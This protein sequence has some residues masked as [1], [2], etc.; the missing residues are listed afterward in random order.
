MPA[1]RLTAAKIR[2]YLPRELAIE[3]VTV[4]HELSSTNLPVLKAAERGEKEGF[5]AVA[6]RQTAG[7]G[8]RGHTFF[9]PDE[10]G[11]YFS[12][13]LRPS[14][15]FPE[16]AARITA[17]AAV[18]LA[19]AV[20]SLFGREPSVKWVNDLFLDDR[21]VAGI[22][23]RGI[24]EESGALSAVILGI[25]VNL[26]PPG[27]GFPEELLDIAGAILPHPIE[28][29]R[30]R[31][32]SAFL[33]EFLPSY[34]ENREFLEEYRRLSF[35]LGRTVSFQTPEGMKEGTALSVDE[36]CRLV[37]ALSSGETVSLSSGEVSVKMSRTQKER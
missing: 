10:T 11:L 32:L 14:Q 4:Y 7:V 13:L 17:R 30:A 27:T 33:A 3:S 21:K 1:D 12:L 23:T 22:L 6:E 18:S 34:R 26:Y 28:D 35:L 31:L 19:H 29:G 36:E 9:S 20:T 37:L 24:A 16:D 2:H 15:F 8:R 25:G 5:L